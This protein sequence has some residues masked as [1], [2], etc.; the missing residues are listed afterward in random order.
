MHP[1]L[2]EASVKWVEDLNVGVACYWISI[3]MKKNKY[4]VVLDFILIE[5][6]AYMKCSE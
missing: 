3:C 2:F 1:S 4:K 5:Y 6:V